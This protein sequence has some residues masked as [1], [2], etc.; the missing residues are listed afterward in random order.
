MLVGSTRVAIA[1]LFSSEQWPSAPVR[2]FAQWL[3]T[4]DGDRDEYQ[5]LKL[6]LV[7]AGIWGN[8]YTSAKTDF[9]VGIVNRARAQQ[10]LPPVHDL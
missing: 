7:A 5:R 4:H 2:L 1:H 10:G 3:R 6:S 9:V 8:A